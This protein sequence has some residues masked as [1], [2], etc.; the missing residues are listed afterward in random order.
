VTTRYSSFLIRLYLHERGERVEVEH[1]QSGAKTRLASVEAATVW[2]RA[3][4]IPITDTPL[5]GSDVPA[6]MEREE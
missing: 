4:T 5:T 3:Q 2:M 6:A 1:V